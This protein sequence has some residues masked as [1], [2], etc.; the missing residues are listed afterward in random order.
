M[1]KKRLK[2]LVITGFSA[3]Y[4]FL[5]VKLGRLHRFHR[6]QTPLHHK[7]KSI[8]NMHYYYFI[9][10]VLK[11]ITFYLSPINTLISVNQMP[12]QCQDPNFVAIVSRLQKTTDIVYLSS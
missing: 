11:M 6:H 9:H 12:K 1:P 7:I 5:S 8:I 10:K 4:S 3:F 2:T